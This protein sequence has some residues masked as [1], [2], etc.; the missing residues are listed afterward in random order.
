MNVF[1]VGDAVRVART[2]DNCPSGLTGVIAFIRGNHAYVDFGYEMEFTHDSRK[3]GGGKKY[4]WILL[5]NL[6]LEQK[7]L[8]IDSI[9]DMEFSSLLGG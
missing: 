3:M 2:Y 6:E 1:Q 9:S 4:Y 8:E 5:S 7:M